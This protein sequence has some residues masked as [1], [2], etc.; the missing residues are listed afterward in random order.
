[1]RN[2]RQHPTLIFEINS[3]PLT[4]ALTL[5]ML[6]ALIAALTPAAQAQYKVIRYFTGRDGA[7][8]EAGVT[9]D[10]AGSLYGTTFGGGTTGNGTVFQL[11]YKDPSF[12]FNPLYSFGG[13]SDGAKQKSLA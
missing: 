3:R 11:K 9:M 6:F 13:G 1:M 8:P 10:K 5:T 12:V 4:I 7:N 2:T